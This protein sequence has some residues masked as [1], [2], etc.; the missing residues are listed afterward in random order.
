M[1]KSFIMFFLSATS[2]EH[3]IHVHYDARYFAQKVTYDSFIHFRCWSDAKWEL[4][5]TKQSNGI[6]K[7]VNS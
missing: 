4:L 7:V 2:D 3:V 1:L 5:E 6:M